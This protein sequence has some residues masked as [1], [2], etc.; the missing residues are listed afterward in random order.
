VPNAL[1][2]LA[3]GYKPKCDTTRQDLAIAEGQFRDYESRLGAAFAH[4]A[5]GSELTALRDRLKAGL[6]GGKPEPGTETPVSVSELAVRIKALRAVHAIEAL[7]RWGGTRRMT[8]EEPVTA[9][10][11]RRN[12]ADSVSEQSR[13]SDFMA[14]PPLEREQC[15]VAAS[16]SDVTELPIRPDVSRSSCRRL[17][18]R[19]F[20]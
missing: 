4:E 6:S 18:A 19:R 8:G 14:G 10:I 11:R 13:P 5:Y 7:P 20:R 2:R 16:D 15:G 17:I 9:K 12:E 3:G 1:E